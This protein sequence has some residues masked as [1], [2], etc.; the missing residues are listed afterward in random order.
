MFARTITGIMACAALALSCTQQEDNSATGDSP[1]AQPQAQVARPEQPAAPTPAHAMVGAARPG[2]RN[3]GR[4]VS[5]EVAGGYVY[6]EVDVSGRRVWLA[7][8]PIP[9]NPGDEVGSG[10]FAPMKNFASKSLGKPFD[11]ILFVANVI[12][13]NGQAVAPDEGTVLTVQTA[14]GYSYI[15]VEREQGKLWIAAPESSVAPGDRITW[16]KGAPMRNFESKSLARIFEEI[17]FTGAVR[18]IE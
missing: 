10:A 17:Y 9:V 6:L 15:E 2:I 11:E 1:P 13:L 18:V 16:E 14:G 8:T 12:P 5:A 7:T 3:R 4:V